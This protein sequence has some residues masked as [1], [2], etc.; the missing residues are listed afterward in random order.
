MVL[1]LARGAV[2]APGGDAEPLNRPEDNLLVG[3]VIEGSPGHFDLEYLLCS[4]TGAA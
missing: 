1:A 3:N 2:A 4:E